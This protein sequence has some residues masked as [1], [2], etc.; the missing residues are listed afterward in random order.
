MVKVDHEPTRVV[1]V[2][3][4]FDDSA[5]GAVAEVAVGIA[6]REE[7]MRRRPAEDFVAGLKLVVANA[8]RWS[9]QFAAGL[10]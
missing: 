4:D 8:D 1:P 10:K 2:T 3:L 7:V 6:W 9:V 5:E